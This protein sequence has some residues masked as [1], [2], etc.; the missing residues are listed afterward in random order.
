MIK[1]KKIFL[2]G[3]AGFIGAAIVRKLAKDNQIVIYDNFRRN[4]FQY[5][6]ID[7]DSKKNINIIKGDILDTGFL[8][9]VIEVFKPNLV[10]HLAAMAGVTDYYNQPVKT[11]EV[12]A[13]GTYSLLEAIK[14]VDIERLVYFSTSEVYGP[15]VFGARE[16]G[17]T[18]QGSLKQMRW[19][20]S[21]SKLAGE[22]MVLAFAQQFKIPVTSVRPFNIY[23]PGQVGEGGVQIFT[24][25]ALKNEIISVTGDGNQIRAWCYI[26]DMLDGL[27]L[28]LT[29][30]E[31]VNEIFNIGDPA[32]TITILSLAKMIIK[33][34]KSK[35]TIKFVPHVGVDIDLRV[36]NIQKAG[37]ILGFKPKVSLEEGLKKSIA[38]YSSIPLDELEKQGA[39]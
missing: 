30:K 12:N 32:G 38:W 13:I 11:M 28:A 22:G 26:D 19:S 37:E 35:S 17:G 2:T 6:N 15:L 3:G 33:L 16:D 10:L 1:G 20:Y 31:A 39:S 21:I 25:K 36:P 23:G 9:G 29:K 4:S 34:A 27:F 18:A 14:G 24:R 7:E 5:F 8:K